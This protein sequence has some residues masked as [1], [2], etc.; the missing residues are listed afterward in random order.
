QLVGRTRF[1]VRPKNIVDDIPIIGGTK[2]PYVDKILEMKPDFILAN[3]EENRPE[4][5]HELQETS[6][7]HVEVTNIASTAEALNMIRSLGSKLDVKNEAYNLAE[8][9]EQKLEKRPSKTPL[10]TA[11]F[12][13][14]EP[15]MSI[16]NDTYIHDV[17]KQWNLINVFGDR[18][19]Y[20]EV[21]L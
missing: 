5:V 8:K 16:G 17:L 7:A 6:T 1:C 11:Y 21:E 13:W 12:I 20:P 9:I 2:S 14:K 10:R 18:T 4:D 3:K 15:W 19:R